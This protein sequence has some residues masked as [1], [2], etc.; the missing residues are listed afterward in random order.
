M[1]YKNKNY[2]YSTA[3]KGEISLAMQNNQFSFILQYIVNYMCS[4]HIVPDIF[5]RKNKHEENGWMVISG[6]NEEE[7]TMYA[8]IIFSLR[9]YSVNSRPPK[10]GKIYTDHDAL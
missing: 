5:K 1:W 8:C 10:A 4:F 9:I 6:G 7:K 2:T 3:Y